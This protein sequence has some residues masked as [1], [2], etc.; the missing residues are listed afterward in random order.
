MTEERK[1]QILDALRDAGVSNTCPM[2]LRNEW[3]VFDNSHVCADVDPETTFQGLE[4]V[5]RDLPVDP[6]AMRKFGSLGMP[7]PSVVIAC[8]KCG[9]VS[10][11]LLFAI[12]LDPA[13]GYSEVV[14]RFAYQ[15]YLYHEEECKK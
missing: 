11:H 8:A 7:M 14:E 15:I 13:A 1:Q 10:Q 9:F 4:F 5:T 2:C 6:A 3:L 12:G